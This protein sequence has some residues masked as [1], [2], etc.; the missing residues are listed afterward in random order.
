MPWE[1]HKPF[2][3][4]VGWKGLFDAC[5][6]GR[7]DDGRSPRYRSSPDARNPQDSRPG[8]NGSRSSKNKKA[9]AAA[10][11]ARGQIEISLSTLENETCP[12][13]NKHSV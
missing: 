10:T 2:A 7:N 12:R 11:Y 3:M 9:K 6:D 4:Q 13:R 5:N 8:K 1:K